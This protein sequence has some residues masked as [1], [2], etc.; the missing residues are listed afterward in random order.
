MIHD[1]TLQIKIGN[2]ADKWDRK[3]RAVV[4]GGDYEF[5]SRFTH[6]CR[7]GLATLIDPNTGRLSI[8]PDYSDLL[9]MTCCESFI[10]NATLIYPIMFDLIS[11]TC[12]QKDVKAWGVIAA[13]RIKRANSW[14][15][16][17]AAKY[18]LEDRGDL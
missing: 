5:L 10:R 6:P 16:D 3:T 12:D 4:Y 13:P 7:K 1:H 14:Q 9:F 8:Y 15:R 2:L 11:S 17:I 18:A